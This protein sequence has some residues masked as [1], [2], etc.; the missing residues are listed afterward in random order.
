MTTSPRLLLLE[1][2]GRQGFVAV[3][4]GSKVLGVQLLDEGRR[5]ARDLAP[6][7]VKLVRDQ[8]WTIRDLDAV[9][10]SC[11]PGSYTGLRVGIMSAKTLAYATGCT[12]LGIETFAVVARQAPQQC[13]RLTVLA[14]AQQE[15][16][17][18]QSFVR[19]PTGWQA[20]EELTI[21]PFAEWLASH[22]LDSWISGPGLSRWQTHL[23]AEARVVAEERQLPGVAG[24]LEVAL[25][26]LAA[27]KRDDPFRLEPLYLRA[28]SA[29][30][31]W[32]ALGR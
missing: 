7:V 15:R 9:A 18:V 27:G 25:E 1:T 26:H 3:A 31:Q 14:D 17:Y 23:P 13:T 19:Q 29:E 4:A 12:L 6:S 24:L 20:I 8:G 10:V 32:Q 28:S 21:R 22:P 2:S 5:H 30:L 16:V 11:G